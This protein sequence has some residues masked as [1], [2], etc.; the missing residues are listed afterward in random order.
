MAL[1]SSLLSF[2]KHFYILNLSV[3]CSSIYLSR[4]WEYYKDCE[5]VKG[6]CYSNQSS[7]KK[8][9]NAKTEPA[10]EN[11]KDTELIF[12]MMNSSSSGNSGNES[13]STRKNGGYLIPRN[14]YCTWSVRL[15]TRSAYTLRIKRG[16]QQVLETI[17]LTVENAFRKIAVGDTELASTSPDIE[18]E[19]WQLQDMKLM[20]IHTRNKYNANASTF[21]IKV[22]KIEARDLKDLVEQISVLITVMFSCCLC[23]T[24]CSV[25]VK[26]RCGL[27]SCCC[28]C[29]KRVEADID[30]A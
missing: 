28:R 4:W 30:E 18:W 13:T 26:L 2:S 5:D 11:N 27:C 19:Q 1:L 8:L 15:D 24:C 14:Y 20:R 17:S 16:Y 23:L 25:L 3:F 9:S 29:C 10:L 21:Q 6:L 7:I 22:S 12:M